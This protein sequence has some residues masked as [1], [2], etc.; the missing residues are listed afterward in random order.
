M[1]TLLAILSAAL[2]L[3][4]AAPLF[5]LTLPFWIV[6]VVTNL[7]CR[8]VRSRTVPW[9]SVIRFEPGLGWKPKENL[10]VYCR[11]EAG[12][13]KIKTDADGWPGRRSRGDCDVIVFGDS[14][15][16]GY[17]VDATHMFSE[18]Q[19]KPRIKPIGA[20]GY[21]MAQELMLMR[22]MS[23]QLAG[24]VVVWFIYIGNDLYDNLQ[25]SMQDYRSPFVRQ[26]KGTNKWEIVNSHVTPEKW[27]YTWVD[28]FRG[29]ARLAAI[30]G[31]TPMSERIYSAC[32]FLITEASG[33][34]RQHG[35][36]L[37]VMT[38]P[39]MVQLDEA[40]WKHRLSS[41]PAS[42]GL[43]PDLPDHKVREICDSLNVPFV[44]GK[45]FLGTRHYLME[46][47]H[48]NEQGHKRVAQMIAEIYK[49][50][51]SRAI[52]LEPEM[53]TT[54]FPIKANQAT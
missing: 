8:L 13:F 49:Q 45:S 23:S 11:F 31:C 3:V 50:Q 25:P 1:R 53:Q 19:K 38:I 29:N 7:L 46:E 10:N 9:Q 20:P 44:A 30:F 42:A 39:T 12:I 40:I 48:W 14:Y 15:A 36:R 33:L 28:G 5:A 17:G 26:S 18:V 21:N 51:S 34:C 54:E 16:F 2:G 32:R 4:L 43:D 24:K 52:L 35:A 22:Q 6:A 37:A 27:P 47:G 41:I